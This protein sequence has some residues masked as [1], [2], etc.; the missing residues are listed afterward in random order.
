[1]ATKVDRKK[2]EEEVE[3]F[4]MEYPNY[5]SEVVGDYLMICSDFN[6]QEKDLFCE[7]LGY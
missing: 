2:V 3:S 5:D 1:M 6:A 7:L 4:K